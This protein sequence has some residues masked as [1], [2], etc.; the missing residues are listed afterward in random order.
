MP[1]VGE[2]VRW[3]DLASM[4][5]GT[6]VLTFNVVTGDIKW[7]R[8]YPAGGVRLLPASKDGILYVVSRTTESVDEF[9]RPVKH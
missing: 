4:T 6:T 7:T 5:D 8:V 3:K 9:G 1:I 2:I